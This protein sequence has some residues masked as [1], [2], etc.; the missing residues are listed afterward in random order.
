M[1]SNSLS[2]NPKILYKYHGI[3]SE[4]NRHVA[5]NII[6][7]YWKH[8]RYHPSNK[9]CY[10][11]EMRKIDELAIEF[12]Y[13]HEPTKDP[14]FKKIRLYYRRIEFQKELEITKRKLSIK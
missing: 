9:L 3:F 4:I 14:C 11:I 1:P 7:S 12:G 2:K 13:I 8:Y 5:A 10:L 6:K